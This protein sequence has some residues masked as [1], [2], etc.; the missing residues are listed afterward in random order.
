MLDIAPGPPAAPPRRDREPGRAPGNEKPAAASVRARF[1]DAAQ[2]LSARVADL[3]LSAALL[4]VM[5]ALAVALVGLISGAQWWWQLLL[6]V[7]VVLGVA[8]GSR[9]AAL[10]RWLAPLLSFVALLLLL[11]AM[12][13][14]RQS[15]FGFIPTP[16]TFSQF[17]D[18]IARSGVSF[19]DQGVPADPLPEFLFLLVAA[20]GG[21]A[22]VCDFLAVVCHRPALVGLVVAAALLA[23]GSLLDTGISPMA[24]ILCLAA[25]LL[26]LRVDVRAK[27][28]TG[29][30]IA[31]SLSIA[32]GAIVVALVIGT[33]APG[34]Q[35]VGR[36]SIPAAGV[37]FGQGVSPLIDLGADLRRPVA[38][39]VID[40]TTT[41]SSPGYLQMTT[42]DA[43]SGE[44][45]RHTRS[46]STFFSSSTSID[47]VPGLSSHVH[48]T[49]VVTD[50]DVH[51][52]TS[53]WLPVPYPASKVEG[54][55]GSWAWERDDLTIS[56][57]TA[58]TIGQQYRVTSSTLEPTAKQLR[59]AGTD[60]PQSVQDDLSV[61]KNAPGVIRTTALSVTAGATT[62]Y[63]MAVALQAYFHDGDFRYSLD[64]P[65]NGGYD[66][67]TPGTIAT[68]LKQKSG[69]C[70]HFAAAMTFMARELG[71]P[72]RIAVG[73]L[74][75]E[76]TGTGNK[77]TQYQVTSDDLHAWPE[78]YFPGV[79]WVPFEP[80]VGR[81]TVP[82]YSTATAATP[83]PS[84]TAS[85]DAANG[86]RRQVPTDKPAPAAGS[87][88]TASA[89]FSSSSSVA[90]VGLLVIALLL[91]PAVIRRRMRTKRLDTLRQGGGTAAAAWAE[92]RSSALDLGLAAPPTETPRAFAERLSRTW[93]GA[94]GSAPDAETSDAASVALAEL[95]E[96]IEQERYGPPGGRWADPVLAD[97]VVTV[98]G[99]IAATAGWARRVRAMLVPVSLLEG[100][101]R[102]AAV[103]S[104]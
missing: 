95:V 5:V 39:P 30:E 97:D 4:A 38:V 40:Y 32:V 49:D 82:D 89:A 87:A 81:G 9:A 3:R 63:D 103:P 62:P 78:L 50:V 6:A 36:Q 22:W 25:Y 54:L 7:V 100:R 23:P 35:Q 102:A 101:L 24:L 47:R 17:A 57:L 79:G 80:T 70:V 77:V 91:T 84:D 12:F 15:L 75:G 69:Y 104:A 2:G 28:G 72:A 37:L 88:D 68:F 11:S 94:A 96:A 16:G 19:Y 98:V 76:V 29:R 44:V 13:A 58:T 20:G 67:D 45:W 74:P 46:Q 61:P 48:T 59:S 71:I 10:P 90:A 73:Y 8:A 18:L 27:R 66:G 55:D 92:L 65:K 33:T 21:I 34:F 85:A 26:L 93:Q 86:A 56:G 43:F 60:Y 53:K 31:A 51:N 41:A 1:E 64:A 42:L 99:A 83:V 14:P 52:M